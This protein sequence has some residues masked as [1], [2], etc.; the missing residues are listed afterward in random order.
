[1]SIDKIQ[2]SLTSRLFHQLIL[3]SSKYGSLDA[4]LDK[5]HCK[6]V[7]IDYG[8][9]ILEFETMA[10]YNWFTLKYQPRTTLAESGFVYAPYIPIVISEPGI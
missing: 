4:Y 9:D 10:Y 6:C 8:P 1:M 3:D 2:I 7:K 5:Y